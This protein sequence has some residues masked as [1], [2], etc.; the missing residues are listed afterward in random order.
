M[1]IKFEKF[2]GLKGEIKY[3]IYANGELI[4]IFDTEIFPNA[5][6]KAQ[7]EYATILDRAKKGYP[8]TETLAEETITPKP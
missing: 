7:K 2:I 5:K 4:S 3:K 6:E 1:T 8:I